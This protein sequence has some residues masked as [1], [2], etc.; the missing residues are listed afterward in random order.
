ML[1]DPKMEPHP[2]NELVASELSLRSI[3]HLLRTAGSAELDYHGSQAMSVRPD[4][5]AK[6]PLYCISQHLV[7]P[8]IIEFEAGL[9]HGMWSLF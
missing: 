8:S 5:V 6:Q 9:Q 7:R 2:Q 4:T 1:L 3:C